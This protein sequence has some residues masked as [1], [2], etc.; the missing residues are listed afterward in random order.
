MEKINELFSKLK[1]LLS[2]LEVERVQQLKNLSHR[3]NV[4]IFSTSISFLALIIFGGN[5]IIGLVSL[6]VLAFS[7]YSGFKLYNE[8][9]EC[10]IN[11]A[12][13]FKN[14]VMPELILSIDPTLEFRKDYFIPIGT[15]TES[16][17]FDFNPGNYSGED[18]IS[19]TIGKT[20]F[21]FCELNIF[22]KTVKNSAEIYFTGQFMV[23]DFNKKFNG[24]TFLFPE[25]LGMQSGLL[26]QTLVKFSKN[27]LEIAKMEDPEFEKRFAVYT[28]DQVEARYILSPAL[29]T[30]IENLTNRFGRDIRLSFVDSKVYIAM[31][32]YQD[33]F[34]PSFLESALN[35]KIIEW[36]YYQ[37]HGSLMIIQE[38]NLNTR[39]WSKQ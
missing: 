33:F 34:N 18:Y 3:K 22:R 35:Q 27:N 17:I 25:V 11:Y 6:G 2:T 1:P 21:E 32:T 16:E 31:Q 23:A 4:L 28:T 12:D 19:G 36:F 38:L 5:Y 15:F 20:K 10:K 24:K 26:A 13:K 14:I 29:M 9:S 30:H 39:I 8:Y 37:L 7:V